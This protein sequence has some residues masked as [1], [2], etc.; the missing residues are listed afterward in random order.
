MEAGLFAISPKTQGT[1]ITTFQNTRHL[2]HFT[3]AVTRCLPLNNLIICILLYYICRESQNDG[4]PGKRS[5]KSWVISSTRI[6]HKLKISHFGICHEVT[7]KQKCMKTKVQE[8]SSACSMRFFLGCFALSITRFKTMYWPT[9]KAHTTENHVVVSSEVLWAAQGCWF[10]LVRGSCRSFLL[11]NFNWSAGVTACGKQTS[12]GPSPALA[13]AGCW[14]HGAFYQRHRRGL[15][16]GKGLK[17]SE[18]IAKRVRA[19][20]LI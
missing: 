5:L 2:C 17:A 3:W 14:E 16:T 12:E 1:T 4:L 19:V 18:K 7:K 15:H 9:F 11:N 6:Q 10:D 20:K 8:T 13:T